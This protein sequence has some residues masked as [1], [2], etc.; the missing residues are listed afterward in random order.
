MKERRPPQRRISGGG[1][2]RGNYQYLI[3]AKGPRRLRRPSHSRDQVSG[4]L[5]KLPSL[6][7]RV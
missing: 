4:S 5:L 3:K 1:T 6:I 7:C 2:T